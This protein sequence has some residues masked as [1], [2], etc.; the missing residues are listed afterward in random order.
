MQKGNDGKK[1]ITMMWIA[2]AFLLL[3]Q[4]VSSYHDYR[5]H[6]ETYNILA[7]F[8]KDLDQ[9]IENQNRHIQ[10]VLDYMDILP[11]YHQ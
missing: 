9:L 5:I 8:Q 1:H 2:I 11:G 7:G 3:A 10:S 4:I 6:Q